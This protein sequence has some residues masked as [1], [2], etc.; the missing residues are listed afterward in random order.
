MKSQHSISRAFR[1]IL[2]LLPKHVRNEHEDELRQFLVLDAPTDRWGKFSY[3]FATLADVLRVAPS[4]HADILRQDLALAARQLRR[5]PTYAVLATLTLAV[6]IAGNVTLFTVVDHT[7]LEPLPF[8]QPEQLVSLSER[9]EGRGFEH[10][11]LSPAN[12]RDYVESADE[13]IE[14]VGAWQSRSGTA[15]IGETPERVLRAA[16]S[17]G[18]FEVFKEIPQ[19]GRAL[20]PEDDFPGSNATVVSHEFWT[21]R[22]GA[23]RSVVG[24]TFALDGTEHR[25][26]GVMAEGFAYPSVR[27]HMWTP[28]GLPEAEWARRGSR[29]LGATARLAEGV[30][31]AQLEQRLIASSNALAELHTD[32][33]DGWSSSLLT[34]RD[35]A[36]QEIRQPLLLVWLAGVLMLLIAIANVANLLLGRSVARRNEM[37]LRRALGA[38]SSR[39]VRQTLTEGGLLAVLGAVVG[40]GMAAMLLSQ[41]R[42]FA[43]HV[44]PRTSELSLTASGIFFGLALSALVSLLFSSAPAWMERGVGLASSLTSQRAGRSLERAQLQKGLVIIEI[45]LAIVVT[46][47][48]SLLTKSALRLL[49]QPLGY[50]PEDVVSF[51]VEPPIRVN[52]NQPM[53]QALA[54][55]ARD[56][57]RI[58]ANFA[59]LMS[60]L[61]AEPSIENA[62]AVSRLPLT[63][64]WWVTGF[65]IPSAPSPG[66]DYSAY[67]RVVSPGYLKTMET[68]IVEGRALLP[69][70]VGTSET[71]VVI[72]QSFALKYWGESSAL[73]QVL[74]LRGPNRSTVP[75]RIVGV[76]EPVRQESLESEQRETFYVTMAQAVGG[77]G[78]NWGM[79]VVLRSPGT[80]PSED[81]LRKIAHE[82]LPEAAVFR[83][84]SMEDLV[85]RSFADRRFHLT[86]FTGFAA[87]AL[88]LT[89]V[90]VFGV[91]ALY[92]RERHREFGVRIALGA[93]P[94]SVRWLVQKNVLFVLAC[95][96]VLGVVATLALANLYESLVYG[97]SAY[98]PASLLQGPGLL[99]L[100][101]LAGG[102]VPAWRATRID[103]A[104]A[105]RDD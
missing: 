16:V 45:A 59:A 66:Q 71:A 42:N 69:T 67:I 58:S 73:G 65:D 39:L 37:A 63:G 75:A 88:A 18:F 84:M 56:R 86:L 1:A 68:R 90:G 33:N 20:R 100:V 83:V 10:F 98:D 23:D 35:V 92:V 93:S 57:V 24:K 97:I 9:H 26:I 17:S 55:F 76:A 13:L 105:L 7:L 22:L 40:L 8:A 104:K 103:P 87:L 38:R 50:V 89:L 4:A 32:T 80:P 61:E 21:S 34:L 3:W 91:L 27:T 77:H 46:V 36:T 95:G 85:S 44:L 29:F 102:M 82:F 43:E 25:I 60:R 79:D 74:H 94:M 81:A 6:G 72:D 47:G 48:A 78:S 49:D 53:E 12:Y 99:A 51:R 11:G 41:L 62:G 54:E 5:A 70:D 28:L 64:N 2:L 15:I 14:S 52:P 96:S 30:T 101:A 19:L 31:P